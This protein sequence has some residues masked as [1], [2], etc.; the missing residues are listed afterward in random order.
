[1]NLTSRS[2]LFCA[3]LLGLGG[4]GVTAQNPVVDSL[5]KYYEAYDMTKARYW[6]D[7]IDY[8]QLGKSKGDLW[9]GSIAGL[10]Y[11]YTDKKAESTEIFNR[12]FDDYWSGK[13]EKDSLYLA[14]NMLYGQ[15]KLNVAKELGTV[16]TEMQP[17][18]PQ[19]YDQYDYELALYHLMSAKYLYEVEKYDSALYHADKAHQLSEWH[20]N[21][22]NKKEINVIFASLL[23][24][25]EER[26]ELVIELMEEATQSK[27]TTLNQVF[28][29]LGS[30]NIAA[31]QYYDNLAYAQSERL[32]LKQLS[33]MQK[34]FGTRQNKLYMIAALNLANLYLRTN[35]HEEAFVLIDMGRKYFETS[36]DHFSELLSA[37]NSLASYYRAVGE[38]DKAVSMH[39]E[40]LAAKISKGISK[41]SIAISRLNYTNALITSY[42]KKPDPEKL[43]LADSL[44]TASSNTYTNL[45]DASY[46][47]NLIARTH[48]VYIYMLRKDWPK[49]LEANEQLLQAK[50]DK[51]GPKHNLYASSLID[52]ALILIQMDRQ[53]EAVA[54][55]Q[56]GVESYL[57]Y[58]LDYL[59]YAKGDAKR[60]FWGDFSGRVSGYLWTLVQNAERIRNAPEL[61]GKF[62]LDTKSVMYD[63]HSARLLLE[64]AKDKPELAEWT[65]LRSKLS[66]VYAS[67]ANEVQDTTTLQ[68]LIREVDA[69]EQELSIYLPPN[70]RKERGNM[71]EALQARLKADE[72]YVEFYRLQRAPQTGGEEVYYLAS[73]FTKDAVKLEVYKDGKA[74]EGKHLNRYRSDLLNRKQVYDSHEVYWQPVARHL[75]GKKRVYVNPDGVFNLISM[76]SLKPLRSQWA[77][78]DDYDLTV[79]GST[80]S[81]LSEENNQRSLKTKKAVLM[82][83]AEN[84]RMPALYNV[85]DE[86][87]QTQTRL[88]NA[89]WQVKVQ[90][91]PE[92]IMPEIPEAMD[93][94][95]WHF[96]G[97]AFLDNRDYDYRFSDAGFLK[98]GL[99]LAPRAGVPSGKLLAYDIMN[100]D[101]RNTQLVILSACETGLGVID[102]G[103]GV[104][105]LRT[106]FSLAGAGASL[107]SLWKVDDETTRIFM[108]AFYE[109]WLSTGDKMKAFKSAQN[110]VRADYPHAYYWGGFVLSE[111]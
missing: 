45:F 46:S 91:G 83:A 86:I 102:N 51:L 55:Y 27:D 65:R 89:Q 28:Q 52:Q 64:N 57:S 92:A 87:D 107:M 77:V 84:K 106:A 19:Y 66:A 21:T 43:D 88:Q 82:G 23:N 54:F 62:L 50:L 100:Y 99:Y 42:A 111:Q 32:F 70:I 95:L 36:E 69:L 16:V 105:N 97:H 75:E 58:T 30:N 76:H 4:H 20:G 104:M 7:Q 73:V 33:M 79:I 60:S 103:N 9:L 2:L 74:L 8:D 47:G 72:A 49:A 12:V 3:L 94:N 37:K 109:A 101:L 39:R 26:P 31:I 34:I 15:S 10:I 80:R 14:L 56:S 29:T 108:N 71:V 98:S 17:L 38:P 61:V 48:A 68:K 85:E 63:Y 11:Y 13:K 93:V 110:K 96:A 22:S 59:P 41:A 81:F 35:R 18:I 5:F 67:S 53:E 40:I 90:S 6:A 24:T 1:M 25:R 78:A 44:I